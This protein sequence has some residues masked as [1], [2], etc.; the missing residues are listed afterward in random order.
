[1]DNSDPVI[2][3]PIQNRCQRKTGKRERERQRKRDRKRDRLSEE[4][5]RKGARAVGSACA[6][7]ENRGME[8]R[9][10]IPTLARSL[11]L[12]STIFL[13]VKI[14]ELLDSKD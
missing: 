9:F 3:C 14:T 7:R 2:T 8:L 12:R 6:G 4:E 10:I 5:G 11:L 13:A 1:M